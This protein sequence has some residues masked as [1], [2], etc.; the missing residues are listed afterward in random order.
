MGLFSRKKTPPPCPPAADPLA[1][2]PLKPDNV[3]IRRDTQGRIHLKLTPVL[4]PLHR[5]VA[6]W[7]HYDYCA[8]VELDEVGSHY[9]SLVDGCHSLSAIVDE[10][11]VKLGKSRD[12]IAM[13]VIE[14]TKSLM[15]RNMLALKVP[16][17]TPMRGRS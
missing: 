1:A 15:V 8:K 13:Q 14:F 7:L 10:M 9:Y 2:V 16:V 5:K 4:K 17:D 11:G 6:V 12:E 3:E